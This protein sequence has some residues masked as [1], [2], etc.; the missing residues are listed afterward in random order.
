MPTREIVLGDWSGA[1]LNG[2]AVIGCGK[3]YD[4]LN[5]NNLIGIDMVILRIKSNEIKAITFQKTESLLNYLWV[6][7]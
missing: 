4:N 2:D 6:W 7:N 3:R 5:I 1:N